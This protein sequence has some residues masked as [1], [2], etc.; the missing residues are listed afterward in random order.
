M[1][2]R[3]PETQGRPPEAKD[4]QI[5]SKGTPKDG[6]ELTGKWGNGGKGTSVAAE[7]ASQSDTHFY[8]FC[9]GEASHSLDTAEHSGANAEST[10]SGRTRTA[11][12]LPVS[13]P[14]RATLPGSQ[15]NLNIGMDFWGASHA[16]SVPMKVMGSILDH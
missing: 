16:G 2:Y 14:G 3:T 5:T 1:V 8:W 6:G 12:K 11:K 10:Y 15:T 13:A 9:S 7:N 4:K